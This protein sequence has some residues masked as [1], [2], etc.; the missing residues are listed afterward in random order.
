MKDIIQK[1]TDTID[2][3]FLSKTEKQEIQQYL[4]SSHLPKETRIDLIQQSINIA[5]DKATPNNYDHVFKWLKKMSALLGNYAIDREHNNAYFTGVDDL[6][7]EVIHLIEKAEKTLD[8]CVFTISDNPIAESIMKKHA[9]GVK[10]R[11]ITDDDK[12]MDMGS[13]IFKLKNKN[14]V[15]KIDGSR[16]HMHHKFAIIDEGT[17][18]TGSFNWTRSASEQNY[19]NIV[20]SDNA[21]LIQSFRK[22]FNRLWE[23]LETLK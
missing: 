23:K 13:D 7:K 6:R 15:V 20:V 14:I 3:S 17:V 22:E 21:Y 18:L 10:V 12:M 5:A 16:S 8:I 9:D 2:D 19:E 11:I 1:I 4:R